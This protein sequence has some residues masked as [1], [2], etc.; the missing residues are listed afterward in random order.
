MGMFDTFY[1]DH[2]GRTLDVQSNQFARVLNNYHLG[3]FVDFDLATPRG[4]TAYIEDYRHDHIDPNC[5]LEWIVL[6]LVD[7]CFLDAYVAESEEEA[8]QVADTMVKLWQSPERQA[9]AFRRHS[10]NHHDARRRLEHTL[11]GVSRLLSDYDAIQQEQTGEHPAGHFA[12]FLRHDFTQESWDWAI[13]RW[14]LGLEE[15]KAG[16]PARYAVANEME[17]RD[18]PGGTG[19]GD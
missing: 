10:Q 19:E 11:E 8:R 5:P 4:V 17:K 12:F 18:G 16:V 7:G 6:L 9:E 13:A 14:L 15:F 1:L 3:D 2:R